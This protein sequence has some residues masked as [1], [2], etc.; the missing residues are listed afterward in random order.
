MILLSAKSSFLT[1]YSPLESPTTRAKQNSFQDVHAK[2]NTYIPF[3]HI[4]LPFINFPSLIT[5]PSLATPHLH[6]CTHATCA[7]IPGKEVIT[8]PHS[9]PCQ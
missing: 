1:Q 5:F 8:C 2:H 7:A 6:P 3:N 9:Q 4:S